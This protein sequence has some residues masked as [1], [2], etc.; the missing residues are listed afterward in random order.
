M[1]HI[2]YTTYETNFDDVGLTTIY[3]FY[4]DGIW[5]DIEYTYNE[6][7]KAYPLED[8]VWGEMI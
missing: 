8:Y 1:N 3:N 6:A 4:P 5:D 2:A 7:L